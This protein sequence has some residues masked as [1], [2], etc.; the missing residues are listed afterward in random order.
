M[1][2]RSSVPPSQG[3][4]EEDIPLRKAIVA[5]RGLAPRVYPIIVKV[6]R[7]RPCPQEALKY[8]YMAGADTIWFR[9]GTKKHQIRELLDIRRHLLEIEQVPPQTLEKALLNIPEYR[10]AR[11]RAGRVGERALA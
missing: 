8:D 2:K 10:R 3:R 1:S 6:L 9:L 11:Q 4:A 5:V 7:Y